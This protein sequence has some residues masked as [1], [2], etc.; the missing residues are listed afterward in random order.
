[1]TE[2]ADG[3]GSLGQDGRRPGGSDSA[4]MSQGL[5][6]D[7]SPP[8]SQVGD[9][10]GGDISWRGPY[11]WPGAARL[12]GDESK[13]F[14][15]EDSPQPGLKRPPE[16]S[17]QADATSYP[18]QAG[19][20]VGSYGSPVQ[21]RWRPG[22]SVLAITEQG[23]QA[24]LSLPSGC[25]GESDRKQSN[26]SHQQLGTREANEMEREPAKAAESSTS[27]EFTKAFSS[28]GESQRMWGLE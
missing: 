7:L 19:L 21:E 18:A 16:R 27:P 8:P 12:K 3:C 24:Y 2:R 4:R 23:S 10:F 6:T 26:G 11:V 5:R 22:G 25:L 17:G 15:P 20:S 1:V 13:A 14:A 28:N 9:H